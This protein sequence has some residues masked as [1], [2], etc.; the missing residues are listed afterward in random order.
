[1]AVYFAAKLCNYRLT[2]SWQLIASFSHVSNEHTKASH[3]VCWAATNSW[4]WKRHGSQISLWYLQPPAVIPPSWQTCLVRHTSAGDRRATNLPTDCARL[5]ACGEGVREAFVRLCRIGI[6]QKL[7]RRWQAGWL[8]LSVTA[9]A[10]AA[11]LI[12]QKSDRAKILW[13]ISCLN[14]ASF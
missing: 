8:A 5:P 11:I 1:M 12:L 14:W 6:V 3:V 10:Q 2:N 13:A 4:S 7:L 9:S